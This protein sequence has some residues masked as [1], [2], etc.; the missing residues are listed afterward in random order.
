[1][2]SPDSRSPEH[3]DTEK[4]RGRSWLEDEP[5]RV[6]GPGLGDVRP[7]TWEEDEWEPDGLPVSL[8]A[9]SGWSSSDDTKHTHGFSTG[10]IKPSTHFL[11]SLA[12]KKPRLH[13]SGSIYAKRFKSD[14]HRLRNWS[15]LTNEHR[16][17][18]ERGGYKKMTKLA[19]SCRKNLTLNYLKRSFYWKKM[20]FT[21]AVQNAGLLHQ[22]FVRWK[23]GLFIQ[24]KSLCSLGRLLYTHKH[25]RAVNFRLINYSGCRYPH[26]GWQSVEHSMALL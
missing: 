25:T 19:A 13:L 18:S 5:S 2:W 17:I 26:N 3:G 12:K 7:S 4:G 9:S 6:G 22:V 15:S 1:M 14:K 16:A 11:S 8:L 21:D 23:K 20:Y 10:V 24:Q